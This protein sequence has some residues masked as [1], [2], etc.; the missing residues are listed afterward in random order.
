M[1]AVIRVKL[2]EGNKVLGVD[3]VIKTQREEV[4]NLI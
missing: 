3:F 1:W 2:W 4:E